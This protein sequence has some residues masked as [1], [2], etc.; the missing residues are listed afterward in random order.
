M[1]QPPKQ[2]LELLQ[3]TPG[4]I[5]TFIVNTAHEIFTYCTQ[6][7]AVLGQS[8][9]PASMYVEIVIHAA[10]LVGATAVSSLEPCVEGLTISGPLSLCSALTVSLHLTPTINSENS[11]TF[12]IL[13]QS[14]D[15]TTA[16]IKHATGAISFRPRGQFLNEPRVQTIPRLTGKGNF[17]DL[18]SAR[19]AHVLNGGIVYQVFGQVVDYAPYYWGVTRIASKGKEAVGSVKV[20]VEQRPVMDESCS[21]PIALDNLLQVAGINF[22]CLSKRTAD[23]VLVCTEMAE[24]FIQ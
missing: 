23:E 17:E 13:S 24:M 19:D 22:N 5:S 4:G 2:L 6:G 20:P 10:D 18:S 16:L 21:A 1:S 7:H 8:L 15:A 9:C 12:T 14:L 3:Q 11:W